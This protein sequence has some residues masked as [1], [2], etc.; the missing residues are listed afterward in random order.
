MPGICCRTGGF[1]ER[2]LRLSFPTFQR[3]SAVYDALRRKRT[4]SVQKGMRRGA[5]HDNRIVRADRRRASAR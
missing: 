5:S 4:Q 2:R 3:G 1:D